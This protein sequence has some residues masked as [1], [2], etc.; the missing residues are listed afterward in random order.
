MAAGRHWPA[1]LSA[2]TRLVV[3]HISVIDKRGHLVTN[4]KENEFK[5]FENGVP[6]Q[7]KLFRHEDVPV[8]MGF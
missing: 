4:L 6:Q 5:V 1:S 2:E 3:L 7:V 8:S